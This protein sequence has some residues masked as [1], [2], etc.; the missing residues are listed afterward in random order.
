[1]PEKIE[2]AL[3]A[4]EWADWLAGNEGYSYGDHRL[5]AVYL[6]GQPFGFTW[7]DVDAMRFAAHI[8]VDARGVGEESDA[9]RDI[10]A[11]IAALLPPRG[12]IQLANGSKIV[13]V[14]AGPDKFETYTPTDLDG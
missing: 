9:L 10:A 7:E 8:I 3:T 5:A 13:G 6:Y 4:E 12:G 14:D 1:M 2:P 11:R